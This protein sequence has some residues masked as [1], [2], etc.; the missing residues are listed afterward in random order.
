M[1]FDLQTAKLFWVGVV[2]SFLTL[3]TLASWRV[4]FEDGETEGKP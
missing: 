1:N 2:T 3:L 4:G